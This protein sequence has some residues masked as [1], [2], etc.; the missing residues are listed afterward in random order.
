MGLGR[1]FLRRVVDLKR[2]GSIDNASSVIEIG[3]QQL[4]NSLLEAEDLLD[5]LYSLSGKPRI[6]LGDPIRAGITGNLENLADNAPSSRTFWQS[7]GYRYSCID[8]DGHRDSFALDLNK[9]SAPRKFR[10]AFDL[11]VN[12]GTTEHVANQDNAF[13]VIHD[14]CRP[15]GIMIHELPAGGMMNH[16]LFNYNLKFFWM[17]CR[18][19]AYVPLYLRLAAYEAVPVPQN[20]YDSNVKFARDSDCIETNCA[21]PDCAIIAVLQKPSKSAYETPLDIPEEL[22]S[23]VG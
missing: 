7:L 6:S 15:G 10:G 22:R 2:S 23:K 20:I 17:L 3:A 14:L 12:T 18:E 1:E 11:V 5:D 4:S 13:R 9:D 16:G 8:F 21:I 19:N